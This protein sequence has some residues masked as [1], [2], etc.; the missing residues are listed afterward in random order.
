[1]RI[2]FSVFGM[3]DGVEEFFDEKREPY[4]NKIKSLNVMIGKRK[5]AEETINAG[6]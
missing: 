1:M 5:S 3:I 2:V 6:R 4:Q